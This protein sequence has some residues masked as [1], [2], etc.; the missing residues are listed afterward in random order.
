MSTPRTDIVV[1]SSEFC[2]Y[3]AA[4]KRLLKQKNLDFT[5]IDVLAEPD[6]RAEMI[7]RSGRRTVPQIFIG[8]RHVGGFDDLNVL[9]KSGELDALI[10]AATNPQ[11]T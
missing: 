8:S 11:S 9:E 3:C 1:Y 6:K 5:E 2:G 4:A 10:A 7:E